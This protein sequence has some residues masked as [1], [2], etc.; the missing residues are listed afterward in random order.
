MSG[1]MRTPDSEPAAP[2]AGET[3]DEAGPPLAVE[4]AWALP[5]AEVAAAL[6]V[7]LRAGSGPEANPGGL[8]SSE[9]AARLARWGPNEL[10]AER[11]TTIF[12][13][14]AR[15][16]A[17]TMVVVLIVAGAVAAVLGDLRDTLVIA[18]IVVINAVIGMFQERR[19]EQALAALRRMTRPTATAL[20]DGHATQIPAATLVPGDVVLLEQGDVVPADLRVTEATGLLA[21]EAVL[22]G[23]SEPVHKVTEPLPGV[24]A[25]QLADQR[26][27]AFM[28]TAIAAGR[29]AGV[30]VATGTRTAFGEIAELVRTGERPST[31]LQ[32]RLARLGRV[33]AV[34]AGA[35]A[36][37]LFGVGLLRGESVETMFLTA[38]S[39][40]VAAIPEALPAVVTIALALGAQRMAARHALV[41]RLPAVET[42]GSVT[43]I[44]TDKTGTVT[45]GRMLA[46][47]A[48]TPDGEFTVEGDGYS[49]DGALL[50]TDDGSMTEVGTATAVPGA[51]LRSL[52]LIAGACN[53]AE[54]ARDEAADAGAGEWRAVGDPTE[55]ALLALAYRGGVAEEVRA[56]RDARLGELPF[57]ASRRRMTTVHRRGGGTWVAVKGA[58]EVLRPLADPDDAA[59]EAGARIADRWAADGYRV[60][61]LA[62]RELPAGAPGDPGAVAELE[63]RL[64]LAGVVGIADPPRAEAA[65]AVMDTR[66]AGISPV[67]VTGD[68]RLTAEAIARRSGILGGGGEVPGEVLEGAQLE[69]LDDAELAERVASVQVYARTNP[70]QKLRIVHAWQRRGAVVAMTGDGVNDAPALKAADIGVAMGIKGTEVSKEAA[71]MVLADDNYAT[72]VAAVEEGRRIYD[73]VRRFLRYLLGTN[74][75]EVWLMT[76]APIIG[77]PLPLL[78]I[79]ILWVNLVTDGLPA[80]ALGVEPPEPG[81][82]RRPPRP[83]RESILA[84]GL[85]QQALLV[86]LVMA[87]VCLLIQWAGIG[88]GW[89]W[90]TMVFTTIALLQLGNA[91]AV[92]SER[93]SV[94]ALGWLSNPALLVAVLATA[95]VQLAIVYVPFLHPIFSTESLGPVELGVVL[96]ASTAAFAVVELDKWWRRRW[97]AGDERD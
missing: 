12:R 60:L 55:A 2:G 58:W 28:G 39:L 26:N 20:R 73:N 46:E 42:L 89:H 11:P 67:M 18:A 15:Q 27:L 43:V 63:E 41:R 85:W 17:N 82:M 30:V 84:G 52:L 44:C 38:V 47:R 71:D 75:G 9:A 23:E 53:H 93:L 86:G 96:V 51:H 35:L 14:L 78:P 31:P 7:L 6:G 65:T 5:A 21:N 45:E 68:H 13:L 10:A 37:L 33:L 16:I 19:A 3:R 70:E 91:L 59:W 34:V 66:A 57:D 62:E 36:L 48:W 76:L 94:F 95:A 40:A 4:R 87:V 25:S 50:R 90:Q 88:L 24:T 83:A 56:L 97:A 29:G 92:R 32:R 49:P 54:L 77:L 72:I 81:I 1:V 80:I 79:H 61:A 64:H 69:S 8:T 74:S 22:S